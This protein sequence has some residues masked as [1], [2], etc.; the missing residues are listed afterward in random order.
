M[1]LDAR[2]ARRR[3]TESSYARIRHRQARISI[4]VQE[5]PYP[6]DRPFTATEAES[7]EMVARLRFCPALAF[8]HE[9]FD[10]FSTAGRGRRATLGRDVRPNPSAPGREGRRGG[11]GP[12]LANHPRQTA[13]SSAHGRDLL[14]ARWP[15]QD[16]P[17]R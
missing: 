4:R 12:S 14:R 3:L 16:A 2:L 8:R 15:R 17:R 13:L 1:D 7:V 9:P 11:G 10:D 5:T 6:E